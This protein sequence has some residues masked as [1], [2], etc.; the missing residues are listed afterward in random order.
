MSARTELYRVVRDLK[1]YLR[2]QQSGGAAGSV[3]APADQREVFEA[4]KQAREQAK[5]DRIKA[6]FQAQTQSADKPADKPTGK[7]A[8]EPADKPQA[9]APSPESNAPQQP[10]EASADAKDVQSDGGGSAKPD[11]VPNFGGPS[12][13]QPATSPD[14]PRKEGAEASSPWK[15]FGSRPQ[16]RF[17]AKSAPA[18]SPSTDEQRSGSGQASS[19]SGSAKPQQAKSKPGPTSQP[20]AKQMSDDQRRPFDDS[21]Y[22]E[23]AGMMREGTVEHPDRA[24]EPPATSSEQATKQP[25]KQAKKAAEMSKREKLDFLRDY[26]GDCRRCGLCEHRTNI[27][28]GTGDAEAKLVFVGE[29]PG[30]N[31]DKQGEPFVGK[32]GQLLDKMI[33]AM[34]L[35]R[36]QVYIC[37][38]IKCR[39]PDN[40]DPHSDEIRQCSPFLR[41]QLEAI[42]PDVIVTLG[43]FAS[44]FVTGEK[45]SMGA[46]RGKWHEW[47]GVAVMP[48]Y[49]PAYLL[50][51]ADQKGKTWSD[52]QMVMERLGLEGS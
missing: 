48:T 8:D 22:P 21:R 31:E 41:K 36:E 9:R 1:N 10:A 17:G 7:P 44:Q 39:P 47:E 4:T 40:R 14:A 6:S 38:V 11:F 23:A 24:P 12:S 43:K 5:L 32:A 2:W 33:D 26:M 42:E 18:K 29:A 3:P 51:S 46:L 52:L 50:R 35:S 15:K 30:Y 13:D 49:H 20:E 27:A 28:F 37:N 34:G 19:E 25:A 45:N 16:R